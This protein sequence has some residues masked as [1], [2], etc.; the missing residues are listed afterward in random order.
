[1]RNCA[2]APAAVR[3]LSPRASHLLAAP[4]ANRK[5]RLMPG[6]SAPP[7]ELVLFYR[8]GLRLVTEEVAEIE[9]ITDARREDP[10]VELGIAHDVETA[11]S[12]VVVPGDGSVEPGLL[13]IEIE[14]PAVAETDVDAALK[15]E[16]PGVVDADARGAEPIDAR[17]G[18]EEVD[19]CTPAPT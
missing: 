6:P 5:A 8:G 3:R 9:A 12:G 7:I 18:V 16:A 1:M 11:E 13:H 15:G 19:D 2:V 4:S 17:A 14:R 10:R